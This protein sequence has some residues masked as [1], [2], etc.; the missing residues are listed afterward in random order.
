[1]E[2]P[3]RAYDAATWVGWL[4]VHQDFFWVAALC[5][6]IAVVLAWRRNPERGGVWA[7][8]PGAGLA[9]IGAAVGQLAMFNP[10]FDVFQDRLVPGSVGNYRPALID[11]HWFTD[12][13][14]AAALVLMVAMWAWRAWAR[15]R[16]ARLRWLVVPAALGV[17]ALHAADARL[18]GAVI[19]LLALA[20]GLAHWNATRGHWLARAALLLAAAGPLWSTIGPV[21]GLLGYLQRQG[22][23]TPMGLAMA[24]ASGVLGVGVLAGLL[25]GMWERQHPGTVVALRR[26]FTWAVGLAVVWVAL[27]ITVAVQLGE[28]NRIEIQQNRLRTAAAQAKVFDPALLAPLS[29]PSFRIEVKSAAGEP[30]AAH[31]PWLRGSTLQA[32]QRRLAQVM[33]ATPF[34]DEARILVVHDGWLVSVLSSGHPAGDG[35]VEILRRAT[36]EDL[37]R[38]ADQQ[39]HVETSPVHEIGYPYYCRAPI[40]AEDGR[41]L[42]WLDCVRREYYLSVERRWRSA[43]FLVLALGIGLLGLL[44]AQRQS[45][46]ESEVS[47]RAADEAAAGNRIKSIFLANVSHELRTP[48]QNILGYGELLDR[49][50]DAGERRAHLAALRGQA[51]LMLRLVNDLI[52]LGAVDAGAFQ[53]AESPVALEP[54]V[55]DTVESLRPRAVAKGLGLECAIAPTLP[56]W[57][58]VD[59]GRVRQVLLNLLGNAVKF[60]DRGRV[61]VRLSGAAGPEGVWRLRLEVEDT[62]PGINPAQQAQLFRAFSR[63]EQS[64]DK[65][66]TG[67]GLAIA[68]RLCAAMGGGLRVESDGRTGSRFVAEFRA[69]V[70]AEPARTAEV[71]VPVKPVPLERPTVVVAEDNRL[72]RDLFVRALTE[73]GAVCRAAEDAEALCAALAQE[74]PQAL[75]L[76]L[77]LGEQDG[78][79]LLPRIR[80][81]APDCRVVIVSAHAGVAERERVRAAGVEEFLTKPVAL[82]ALWAAVAGGRR[83]PAALPDFFAQSPALAAEARRIFA[84]ELPAWEEIVEAAHRRGDLQ[85]IRRQAHYLRSGALAVRSTEIFHAAAELERAAAG[86]DLSRVADAWQQCRSALQPAGRPAG[87]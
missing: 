59:G 39:A 44:L 28:D 70:A 31:S 26:D 46:R 12:V 81:L 58:K 30:I 83:A 47:R 45:T 73:R 57:V 24:A 51:E 76:D 16:F 18:G 17:L 2:N 3:A 4:S 75:V 87:G 19:A 35:Q 21:A 37:S 84:A 65:E 82:D 49:E 55:R 85:T 56:A 13:V 53:L 38:W 54:L 60:T 66:G 79:G 61:A 9:A 48:L 63:L 5:L 20:L 40:V 71:V 41:M 50:G 86:G 77:G 64:A 22:P 10:T 23:P 74:P 69:P 27:G 15:T 36:P 32:A 68:A 42:G 72:M 11:P 8:V 80:A 14:I 52:D 78:L 34:L 7:W 29:D 33:I 25:R 6:W 67:L 43:P 1:M 62:G